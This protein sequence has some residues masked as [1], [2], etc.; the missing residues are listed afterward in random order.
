M[1]ERGVYCMKSTASK[2]KYCHTTTQEIYV[3]MKEG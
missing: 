3:D 2:G 1:E